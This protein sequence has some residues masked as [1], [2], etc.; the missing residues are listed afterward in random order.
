[1]SANHKI[2]VTGLKEPNELGLYDMFGNVKEMM[3]E[4]FKARHKGLEIGESG[5][6]VVRGGSF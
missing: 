2:Q 5:G 4:R 3:S 6:I 1:M